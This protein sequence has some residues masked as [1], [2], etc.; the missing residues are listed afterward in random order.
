MRPGEIGFYIVADG[1]GRPYKCYVRSPSFVHLSTAET[2]IK[3]HLIGFQLEPGALG[4]VRR[5]GVFWGPLVAAFMVLLAV[6][7]EQHFGGLARSRDY[8]MTYVYP[9]LPEVAPE[10]LKKL[11]S[12]R[13]FSTFFYP[14][15]LAGALLLLLPA[16]LTF[17]WQASGNGR[18]TPGA[19]VL[20]YQVHRSTPAALHRRCSGHRGWPAAFFN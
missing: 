15:S 3:G 6:G 11:N 17:V 12:T 20:H 4:P 16:L 13:I 5:S 1:T 8:F 9:T 14:N 7:W 18:F 10:Y 19:H 2:L